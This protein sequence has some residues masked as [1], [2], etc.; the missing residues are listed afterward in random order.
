MNKESYPS[1]E[2]QAQ[3]KREELERELG[4]DVANVNLLRTLTEGEIVDLSKKIMPTILDGETYEFASHF[5]LATSKDDYDRRA[6][7]KNWCCG[8]YKDTIKI[9]KKTF[10]FGFDYGH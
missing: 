6:E 10:Y 4:D 9:G 3:K 2:T 1:V 5:V 7:S 8:I